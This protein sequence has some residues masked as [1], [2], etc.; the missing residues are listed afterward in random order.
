MC[1]ILT[2][3]TLILCQKIYPVTN[4]RY[5]YKQTPLP[6]ILDNFRSTK[7]QSFLYP[8][9]L[10]LV[11]LLAAAPD[12]FALSPADK[13]TIFE[14][15]PAIK[16]DT[17]RVKGTIQTTDTQTGKIEN[18]PSVIIRIKETQSAVVTNG[19]G[20]FH[21]IYVP[22]RDTITLMITDPL[23]N[24]TTIMLTT[25]HLQDEIDMGKIMLKQAPPS[26]QEPERKRS[27]RRKKD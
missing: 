14:A 11:T 18:V 27:K 16:T 2:K 19:N 8:V 9:F 6:M 17:V 1:S 7:K 4:K 15:A 10:A 20:D 25:V 12:T 3:G 13:A 22:G 24:K 26:Q 5:I 21:F 23:Y